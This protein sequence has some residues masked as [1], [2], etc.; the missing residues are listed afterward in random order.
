MYI[1]TEKILKRRQEQIEIKRKREIEKEKK[2][3]ERKI[4]EKYKD[5]ETQNIEKEKELQK[6]KDMHNRLPN[7]RDELKNEG[8]NKNLLLEYAPQILGKL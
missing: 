8:K 4:K 2:E 6:L 7:S 3:I 5:I 1:E